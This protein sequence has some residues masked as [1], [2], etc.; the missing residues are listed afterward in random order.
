MDEES[1]DKTTFIIRE[2]T[3]R[4]RVMPFGLTSAPVTLQ[5]L[6]DLEMSGLN[7]DMSCQL[8]CYNCVLR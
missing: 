2:G 6:M 4:F 7:L 8:K 5:R 3:F 1:R